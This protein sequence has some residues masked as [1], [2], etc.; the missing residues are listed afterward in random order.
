MDDTRYAQSHCRA[1]FPPSGTYY[2]TSIELDLVP[3]KSRHGE[4]DFAVV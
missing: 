1:D 4:G 2:G 3:C